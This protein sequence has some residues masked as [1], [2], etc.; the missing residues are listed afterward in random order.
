MKVMLNTFI[1]IKNNRF[2]DNT[3][4]AKPVRRQNPLSPASFKRFKLSFG[5]NPD[6]IKEFCELFD[7]AIAEPQK[8]TQKSLKK[9]GECFT[10]VASNSFEENFINHGRDF[11][12]FRLNDKY[13][14][15]MPRRCHADMDGFEISDN[16]ISN[17]LKTWFGGIVAKAGNVPILKNADPERISTLV[18]VPYNLMKGL[19]EYYKEHCLPKLMEIPQEAFDKV[20]ADFKILDGLSMSFDYV[21]PNNFLMVGKKIRVVDNLDNK[22]TYRDSNNI[23]KMFEPFIQVFAPM[24]SVSFDKNLV[25]QRQELLK[26]CVLASERAELRID[27]FNRGDSSVIS[28]TLE[29]SG[30]KIW[31]ESLIKKLEEFR[32]TIPDMTERLKAVKEY[33]DKME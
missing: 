33:L 21:N 29:L 26:K 28:S 32:R 30:L 8:V 10:E 16:K 25:P 12:V 20:A 5:A 23:A 4:Q 19:D 1:P 22:W 31:Q 14:Y 2:V 13:V 27:Y 18:G 24:T 17:N 7:F 9:L 3:N 6:K 11:N 15:K